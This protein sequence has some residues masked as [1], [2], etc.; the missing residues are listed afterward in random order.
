MPDSWRGERDSNTFYAR[1]AVV[2]R[3]N[4]AIVAICATDI[5]AAPLGGLER[6]ATNAAVTAHALLLPA[7]WPAC[8]WCG[9][10]DPEC[11]A[12]ADHIDYDRASETTVRGRW[13]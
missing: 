4:G 13:S 8:P 9:L 5:D 12:L 3:V 1:T 10:P 2:E 7:Q 6:F 11:P